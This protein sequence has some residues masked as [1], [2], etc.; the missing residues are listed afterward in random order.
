MSFLDAA[1]RWFACFDQPDLKAPVALRRSCPAGLG[2]RRQRPGHPGR[3][4]ALADRVDRTARHVLHDLVAG[5]YHVVRDEHDGMPLRPA[6]PPV[7]GRAPRPRGRRAVRAHQALHRPV[8][9]LFGVRYPWGEYHQ[10]FVPEFNAGAMENPGCVTFRD[11]MVFRSQVT[12]NERLGRDITIAH[13]MAHMWFGD[14][15]TMRWWD[16]LWLNESFA[17]YLGCRVARRPA[18]DAW[19]DFGIVGKPWGFVADRRPSTHPVAGNGAA[20][21]ASAMS[22]FDG[23]SYAKGAS[24]L[25]QLALHLGD[26]VFFA[27]LRRHIE[28]HATGRRVRRPDGVVLAAGATELD[29]WAGL[30]LHHRCRQAARTPTA[31]GSTISGRRAPARGPGRRLRRVRDRTRPRIASAR[32]RR[33]HVVARSGG[34]GRRRRRRRDVGEARDRRLDRGRDRCCPAWQPRPRSRSGTRCSWR[35]PTPKSPPADRAGPRR[36]GCPRG[37]RRCSSQTARVG[38]HDGRGP[39][40]VRSRELRADRATSPQRVLVRGAAGVEPAARRR[41]CLDRRRRRRGGCGLARR[42]R[43]RTG[44]RSTPTCAGAMLARLSALGA[45]DEAEIAAELAATGRPRAS[46][47]PRGAARCDRTRPRTRRLAGPDRKTPNCRTSSCTRSPTASGIRCRRRS[48]RRTSSATSPTSPR[49][50]PSA[51]SA[52]SGSS[53]GSRSRARPS[54]NARWTSRPNCWH[55]TTS[56][57]VSGGQWST[58]RTTPAR[59]RRPHPLP[60]LFASD[61]LHRRVTR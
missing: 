13:E 11:T 6:R 34:A 25:R 33:S 46:C 27:G 38:D 32:R 59:P 23:I 10:A 61:D 37:R 52:W 16:D 40:T 18:D 50:P 28:T 42:R 7:A 30:A 58:E 19:V 14:L 44:S 2:G 29:D 53:R 3:A 21:A 8:A 51:A 49:P 31:T 48:P 54:R 36:R 57:P 60:Q 45:V 39:A 35:R 43:A 26:D 47:A 9:R 56:R 4:G 15:V 55:A 20:D 41:P 12:D 24:V 22:E 5:P 1:P 17:E